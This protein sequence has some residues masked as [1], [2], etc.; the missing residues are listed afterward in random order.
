MDRVERIQRLHAIE[1]THAA[2]R[3]GLS[4]ITHLSDPLPTFGIYPTG[5]HTPHGLT[6]E[7]TSAQGGI[8]IEI[9]TE[10]H[11]DSVYTYTRTHSADIQP[12]NP[13]H[14]AHL[15]AEAQVSDD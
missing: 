4:I 2:T 5:E 13:A 8:C 15:F 10:G 1:A 7:R 11:I 9:D 12:D 14:A 6:L 3:T